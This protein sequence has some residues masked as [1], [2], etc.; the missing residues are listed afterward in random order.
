MAR[1]P[2]QPADLFGLRSLGDPQLSPDGLAVAVVL[3][4]PNREADRDESALWLVEVATGDLRPLTAGP[5]DRW[6]RWSPDGQ[7][8]AFVG[9]QGESSQVWLLARDSTTPRPLVVLPGR[10]SGPPIWRPDGRALAVTVLVRPEAAGDRPQPKVVRRLRTQ[11]EGV[12]D[13]L[14]AFW[15]IFVIDLVG[16]EPQVRPLTT[17]PWH[18]FHPA[19]SPD[20]RWLALVTTRRPDW[21]LEWVWDLYLCQADGRDWRRLTPS[22][23][24]CL[25]PA[26]SPD[27]E[28]LAYFAN[29]C[30]WTATTRDYH[31]FLLRVE[32]GVPRNLSA[33]L[34]RGAV[35]APPPAPTSPPVWSGDGTRLTWLVR[36]GGRLALVQ[37]TLADGQVR[38]LVQGDPYPLQFSQG[39]PEDSLALV[40]TDWETPADLFLAPATGAP[41]R[42]LTRLN[43][44][45][46]AGKALSRPRRVVVARPEGLSIEGWLWPPVGDP[47]SPWPLLVHQ[48]GGPHGA[49]GP[50]FDLRTQVLAGAGFAVLSVNW[51]G[52]AGYGAAFA[53]ALE[54]NWGGPELEDTLLV[55]DHLVAEGL[56]DPLCLGV[57]GSSYGG[58]LVNLFL[59]RTDRFRAGVTIATIS[60]LRTLA[61]Q[62]DQWESIEGDNGGPPFARPAYYAERSPL[63]YVERMTAPLLI[64]H[65]EAD[66]TCPIGEAVQLF[67]ALRRLR[68]PVELVRYPGA[69]H[70]LGAGRPGYRL[71]VLQ[72]L[73]AWFRQH[74]PVAVTPTP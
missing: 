13:L 20:G 47:P 16:S 3:T 38:P 40:M 54:G 31:L 53:Q 28:W 23:G 18:H 67:T 15:Q 34:D 6:P 45:M 8:L 56:V 74:L 50:G 17:G 42:R 11:M 5:R 65:G 58:Y 26:W 30:P 68:R 14:D 21:D 72:R 55:L 4:I 73:L 2:L 44:P 29:E 59:G 1:S 36:D 27:G 7:A 49:V 25:A 61:Y 70:A 39:G 37:C 66:L 62:T 43:A 35:V 71:D 32:E 19:W 41:L 9:D 48:H 24:V 57:Y 60:D 51:R 33:S 52:S 46:L 64:L 12:G 10:V 22:T 69:G 63:T